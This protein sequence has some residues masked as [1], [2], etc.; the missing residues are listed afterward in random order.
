[1]RPHVGALATLERGYAVVTREA[2][3]A[4]LRSARDARAADRVRI[5]LADGSVRAVI[6]GRVKG[7]DG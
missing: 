3:A 7:E 6:E 4:L 5:R 1:M 2:D